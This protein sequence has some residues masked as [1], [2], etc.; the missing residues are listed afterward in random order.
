MD[1]GKVV[2]FLRALGCSSIRSKDRWVEASCPLARWTHGKS[3]TDSR[4]SFGVSIEPQGE[5]RWRCL[6]CALGGTLNE[7]LWSVQRHQ[8]RA[9]ERIAVDLSPLFTH[10]RVHEMAGGLAGIQTK[11]ANIEKPKEAGV[12]GW[13]TPPKVDLD[14]VVRSLVPLP[15]ED[16]SRF[17]PIVPKSDAGRYL[18]GPKRRLPV[19]AWSAWELGWH[20]PSR[21]VAIPVR[22]HEGR[23]MGITGKSI[24]P[25]TSSPWRHSDGFKRNYLLFGEHKLPDLKV[26]GYLVEG[27]F[28]VMYLWAHGYVGAVGVMG[29]YLSPYQLRQCC[30]FFDRVVIFRDGDEAGKK[31]AESFQNDLAKHLPVSVPPVV[32]G[33]DPDQYTAEE[34]L[35][36]IGPP[37]LRQADPTPVL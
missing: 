1:A 9:R 16:L 14:A 26:T 31:A 35:D 3:G 15:E 8:Q 34:L 37:P 36:I 10:V 6:G 32:E 30:R 33:R 18:L 25:N 21:R 7:L 27:H 19:H 5:S 20:A 13:Y 2:E 28:D 4:P 22:D 29:S 23:L 17:E 11:L 24:K 12:G